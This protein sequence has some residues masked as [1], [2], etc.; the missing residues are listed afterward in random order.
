MRKRFN[1]T[2]LCIPNKHFMVD[3]SAKI[4]KV[5][6]LVENGEY[7]TINRPRQF[8]KTTTAFLLYE[9]LQIQKEYLIIDLSFEGIGDRIFEEEK[10]IT[11]GFWQMISKRLELATEEELHT[12]CEMLL[13]QIQSFKH[14]SESITTLVQ[15]SQRKIILLIDEVDKSSNNILFLHLLGMFRDKYLLQNRGIDKSFHSVI[16]LGVHDIKNLKRKIRPEDAHSLNSP[17]NIAADFTV[18]MSFSATE[19]QTMLKQYAEETDISMN[20]PEIAEKIY[21]YTSGYPYLVSKMCKVIDEI[22]L[23]KTQKKHWTLEN[24]EESFRYLV[25]PNHTTTLFDDLAKNLNNNSDLYDLVFDIVINGDKKK[26]NLYNPTIGLAATYGILSV[27]ES[28][29]CEVHNR[30]FEKIVYDMML[31]KEETSKKQVLERSLYEGEN[32]ELLLK[33]A[34]IAFQNF[35]RENHSQKDLSFLEREGRLLFLSFLKPILNGKGFD[36]KEP[37]VGDERRVDI[38]ITY[39]QHKYVLELKRWQGERYHEKGLQQLSD[40]LDLHQLKEDFLLIY[41]FRKTKEYK[42]ED[43]KFQDKEIFAVWV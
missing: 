18:D 6:D 24:L 1:D 28:G 14:L 29:F 3:T 16:L 27:D 22:I 34:L 41:D 17:W 15:K 32:G 36:F 7:F 38:V 13:P 20:I 26:F 10:N 12:I 31:S 40:Y 8:G 21:Y 4:E 39:L 42:I 19:I 2:G 5:M 33:P 23:P 35:M 30:I 25:N 37:V 9:N 11:F 43:I